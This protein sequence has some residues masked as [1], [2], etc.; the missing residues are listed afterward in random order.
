LDRDLQ[1]LRKFQKLSLRAI[2]DE[3]IEMGGNAVLGVD[4]ACQVLG[5]QND[6]MVLLIGAKGTAVFLE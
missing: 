4:F 6:M 2:K 3:T 1:S 5:T